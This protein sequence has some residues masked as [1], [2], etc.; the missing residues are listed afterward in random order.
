MRNAELKREKIVQSAGALFHRQGYTITTLADIAAEAEVQLG[1][2]YYYFKTKEELVATVVAERNQQ[3]LERH[4]LLEQASTPLKRLEAFLQRIHDEAQ[5]RAERGCPMGGLAQEAAKL[6]GRISD[7]A[8][9]TFQLTLGWVEAQ[10]IG[11]GLKPTVARERAVDLV[12]A[13]QGS[14]LLGHSLRDPG[15]IRQ[16]MKRL[17]ARL[18]LLSKEGARH[19]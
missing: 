18:R 10:H 9:S 13:V 14:I 11:M 15:L 12:A 4:R 19:D 3:V 17:Q 2:V 1:N 16:A 8:A 5:D 7:E 6:G